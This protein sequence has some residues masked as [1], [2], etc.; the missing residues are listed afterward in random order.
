MAR[1]IMIACL[2][3][4]AC[5]EKGGRSDPSPEGAAPRVAKAPPAPAEAGDEKVIRRGGAPGIAIVGDSISFGGQ[6]R[7]RMGKTLERLVSAAFPG[8]S[9]DTYAVPGQTCAQLAE[10]FEGQVIGVG[11]YD[12][13]VIQCG[14]NDLYNGRELKDVVSDLRT[15]VTWANEAG[16]RPIVLDVGPAHGYAGWTGEKEGRRAALNR[17]IP[18]LDGAVAVDA[19]TVLSTGTPPRLKDEYFVTDMI[20]P[21]DDGLDAMAERIFSIAYAG[22]KQ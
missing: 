7:E 22:G 11:R 16:V 1:A 15:M 3:V 9:V 17:L 13:V 5:G 18:T 21:N 6:T 12:T 8:A 19:S 14:T 10:R 2:L 20:H 4:A